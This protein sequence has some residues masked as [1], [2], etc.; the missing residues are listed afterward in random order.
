M[1]RLPT[2]HIAISAIAVAMLPAGL[3]ATFAP[4]SFFDDF[5]LG[6]GWISAGGEAFNE[7]LVRDVGGLFLA[8]I[9]ATAWTVWTRGPTTAVALAWLVQ[10]VLH[11]AHHARHLHDLGTADTIGLV[12]T[13]I[14]VPALAAVALLTPVGVHQE[15]TTP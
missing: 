15:S 6:R 8:L 3:Q 4:R 1:T 14:A 2:S 12:V 7:H 9:V 10:G 13:L 11:L 5:P